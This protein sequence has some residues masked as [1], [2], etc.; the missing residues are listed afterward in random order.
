[1]NTE[2]FKKFIVKEASAYIK[3]LKEDGVKTINESVEKP[4]IKVIDS[5][6]PDDIK[7]LAKQISELNKNV[8]FRNPVINESVKITEN[9]VESVKL[10]RDADMDKY[11]NNKNTQHMNESEGEKWKRMLNYNIPS[12]EERNKK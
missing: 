2:E 5:V 11:N 9:K 7:S 1:M 8:D 4:A 3:S 6:S 10:T 12:D